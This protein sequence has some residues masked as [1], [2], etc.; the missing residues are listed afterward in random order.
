[1]ENASKALLIAGGILLSIIVLTLFMLMVNSL[2]D[3]QQQETQTQKQA[4][5]I[6]FNNQFAGYM[7][8]DVSGTDIL[9][10]INKVVYYN[11]T[12]STAG[13]D[14]TDSGAS[15]GSEPITVVID[16]QNRDKFSRN[17]TNVLFKNNSYTFGGRENMNSSNGIKDG[18]D[19]IDNI[20]KSSLPDSPTSPSF[21]WIKSPAQKIKITDGILKGLSDNYDSDKSVFDDFSFPSLSQTDKEKAQRERLHEF[22]LIVGKSYFPLYYTLN[23]KEKNV[24]SD[25]MKKYWDYYLGKDESKIKRIKINNTSLSI[26]EMVDYYYEYAQFQ[27]AKFKWVQPPTGQETYSNDGKIRYLKFEFTGEF[28]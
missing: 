3:Y 27:R 6:S 25:Q 21:N 26:R 8:D 4:D 10:L 2:T 12:K 22:N 9:S 1:M 28:I 7:R 11:K 17:T 16:I 19:L 18:L 23:G 15:Y 24:D 13:T 20:K 5:I 14:A